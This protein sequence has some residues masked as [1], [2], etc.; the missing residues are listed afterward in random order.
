MLRIAVLSA[1]GTTAVQK[2][3]RLIAQ[4]TLRYTTKL[5]VLDALG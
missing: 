3:K 4:E 2:S 1:G 5:T